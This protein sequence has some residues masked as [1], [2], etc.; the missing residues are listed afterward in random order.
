MCVSCAL[1]SIV[2]VPS[3]EVIEGPGVTEVRQ[4][5]KKLGTLVTR[6]WR[7]KPGLEVEWSVGPPVTGMHWE[8][9]VRYSSSIASGA[10]DI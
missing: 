10:Y 1:Q 2:P 6:L 7:G 8:M 4:V 5:F 3:I 9:F